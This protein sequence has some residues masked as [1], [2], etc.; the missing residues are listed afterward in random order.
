MLVPGTVPAAVVVL[1]LHG[2]YGCHWSWLHQG[3]AELVLHQLTA[4]GVIPPML[5]VMP[6]DG[7]RGDGSAYAN[8]G[9]AD[10]ESWIVDAIPDVVSAMHECRPLPLCIGGLSMGG[11][12]APG[13]A[14]RHSSSFTAVAAHSSVTSLEGLQRF[15]HAPLDASIDDRDLPTL[16]FVTDGLPPLALD[17]GIDDFL[18]RTTV[19]CTMS[20]RPVAWPTATMRPRAAM[21][22][23]TGSVGYPVR[24]DSSLIGSTLN[25]HR[26]DI[27]GGL[28]R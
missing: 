15:G 2:V 7:G 16:L 17:G 24:C 26:V 11:F 23:R 1:L 6:S 27:T 8:F 19:A 28:D 14:A 12:G 25:D 9:G 3:G 10:H 22:G 13:L 5:L 20:S 18:S 4:A 21:S